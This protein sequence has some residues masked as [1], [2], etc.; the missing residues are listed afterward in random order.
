VKCTRS[1]TRDGCANGRGCAFR[2][3]D[4]A[5]SSS[6]TV[7]APIEAKTKAHKGVKEYGLG[8][9][10][11]QKRAR[12]RDDEPGNVAQRQ[13]VHD[14]KGDNRCGGKHHRSRGRGQGRGRGGH[15]R[16]NSRGRGDA[17]A[18]RPELHIRGFATRG[19]Q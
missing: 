7:A 8:K 19:A 10:A 18:S 9:G 5:G 12:E 16:G 14:H 11:G 13:R 4:D 6:H 1:L 3:V 15:V 2:H 17:G